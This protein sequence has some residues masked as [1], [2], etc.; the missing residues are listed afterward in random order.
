MMLRVQETEAMDQA[1]QKR[2]IARWL[3]QRR[4]RRC[5]HAAMKQRA[6]RSDGR[7]RAT[8]HAVNISFVP[9]Q[10]GPQETCKEKQEQRLVAS[11]RKARNTAK[12]KRRAL[13]PDKGTAKSTRTRLAATYVPL[14]CLIRIGSV[15]VSQHA[16]QTTV[17]GVSVTPASN[18]PFVNRSRAVH[19]LRMDFC[20]VAI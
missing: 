8:A 17:C 4:S 3:Q 20:K 13:R 9:M 1:Q 19:T 2:V 5:T 15:R 7:T 10:R 18:K 11:Q 14:K 12:Y 16:H 6:G